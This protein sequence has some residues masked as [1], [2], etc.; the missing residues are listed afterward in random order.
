MSLTLTRHRRIPHPRRKPHRMDAVAYDT[1]NIKSLAFPE[2]LRI[3]PGA[4]TP[5]A[6]HPAIATVTHGGYKH[7]A[8]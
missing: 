4:A 6:N 7:A 5:I 2:R 1:N 3:F 8:T